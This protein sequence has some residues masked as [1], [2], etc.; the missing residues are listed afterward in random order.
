MCR[1]KVAHAGRVISVDS[2]LRK[3]NCAIEFG[4]MRSASRVSRLASYVL[5]SIT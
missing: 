1:S 3:S 4:V 2:R 5:L